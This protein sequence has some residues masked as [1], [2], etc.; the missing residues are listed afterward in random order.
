MNLLTGIVQH[1]ISINISVSHTMIARNRLIN[2][3]G[4]TSNSVLS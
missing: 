2:N 1:L 4:V 3:G